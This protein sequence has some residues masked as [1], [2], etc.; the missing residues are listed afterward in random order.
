MKVSWM[1]MAFALSGFALIASAGPGRLTADDMPKLVLQGEPPKIGD[2]TVTL[3]VLDVWAS[4][5][6]PC[7]ESLPFNGKLA[8][9]LAPRGVRFLGVSADDGAEEARKF[10]KETPIPFPSVWDDG[11]RLTKKLELSA[12]P[13]LV[14]LDSEGRILK[15]T[16]GFT[17]KTKL[18]LEPLIESFLPKP[19]PPQTAPPKTVK[20]P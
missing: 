3:I 15:Q 12:I 7:K 4:W 14:I 6:D 11:G 17:A 8:E 1:F 20:R 16:T 19:V 13:S 9:R 10:L 2:P 5:C 18:E